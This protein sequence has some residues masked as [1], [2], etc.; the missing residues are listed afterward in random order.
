MGVI[1]WLRSGSDGPTDER[2]IADGLGLDDDL[3]GFDD[4]GGFDDLDGEFED[5]LDGDDFDDDFDDGFGGAFDGFDDGPGGS[6]GGSSQQV[7]EL[8]DRVG[9][10]ENEVSTLSSGMSTVREENKQIG[11]TVDDL[12]D[13]IRK[14]LD[15]YEMVTRGINPFVDDAQAMGG[16]D[17]SGAFG[18]FDTDDDEDIGG[19]LDPGVASADAESFFDDDFGELDGTTEAEVELAAE[20]EPVEERRADPSE[21]VDEDRDDEGRAGSSFE[22]LKAEYEEREAAWADE[23]PADADQGPSGEAEE[24]DALAGEADAAESDE[25]AESADDTTGDPD[26]HA[27]AEHD[28]DDDRTEVVAGVSVRGESM[29]D[30]EPE[31]DAASAERAV[32]V[33]GTADPEAEPAEPVETDQTMFNDTTSPYLASLPSTYLAEYLVLE[34]AEYLVTEGG[35]VGAARALRRYEALGW[36]STPVRKT[37]GEYVDGVSAEATAFGDGPLGVDDH[38]VSLRYVSRLAG[39]ATPPNARSRTDTVDGGSDGIRG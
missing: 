19:D 26:A 20:D 18:I 34:W 31:S 32:A 15:I 8:E 24:P 9:E 17:T 37:L 33:E 4:L 25:A 14:L 29:S 27:L 7:A 3:D 12:D 1:D 23:G 28:R 38:A 13:T 11:E 10:L 39:N 6:D 36:V 35:V 22:E 5:D 2:L 16:L 21:G 30:P